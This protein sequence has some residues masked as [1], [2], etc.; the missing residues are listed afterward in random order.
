MNNLRKIRR[1]KDITQER[2]AE[3][4]SSS[5]SYVCDLENGFIRNPSLGKARLIAIQLDS[6]LDEIFPKDDK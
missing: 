1:A 6:T 5:K 3:L 4:I 2:L